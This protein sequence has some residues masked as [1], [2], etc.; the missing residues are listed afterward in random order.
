MHAIGTYVWLN[1]CAHNGM[2]VVMKSRA[3]CILKYSSVSYGNAYVRAMAYYLANE[4]QEIETKIGQA[5]SVP[6]CVRA[7]HERLPCFQN[8]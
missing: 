8:P 2:Q 3:V 1:V 7:G 4:G 6:S 5:Q